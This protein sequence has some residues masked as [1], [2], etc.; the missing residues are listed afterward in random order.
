MV[1]IRSDSC[2]TTISPVFERKNVLITAILKERVTSFDVILPSNPI[3]PTLVN[4]TQQSWLLAWKSEP[5]T[6]WFFQMYHDM[7]PLSDYTSSTRF[8]LYLGLN[9]VLWKGWYQFFC[10]AFTQ[11]PPHTN[12]QPTDPR[13]VLLLY[14]VTHTAGNILNN[15]HQELALDVGLLLFSA[16]VARC[17]LLAGVKTRELICTY[18]CPRGKSVRPQIN[19]RGKNNV[20]KNNHNDI[21]KLLVWNRG[22]GSINSKQHGN[23]ADN[24]ED[25][26]KS[27]I[28][29]IYTYIWLRGIQNWS[30]SP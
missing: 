27:M 12:R 13:I 1:V 25:F 23:R 9:E 4:L 14:K 5:A 11:D 15:F 3:S 16:L 18:L 29:L 22:R 26:Y 24:G 21:I 2:S 6:Y 20:N 7:C 17:Y 30:L 28:I 10:P 8:K 19:A